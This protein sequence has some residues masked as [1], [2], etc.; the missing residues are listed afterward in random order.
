LAVTEQDESYQPLYTVLGMNANW[1]AMLAGS[2][3]SFVPVSPSMYWVLLVTFLQALP[4][5]LLAV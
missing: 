4:P 2:P 5:V 1:A 3:I